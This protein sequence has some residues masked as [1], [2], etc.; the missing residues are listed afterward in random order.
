MIRPADHNDA[1]A[2]A[3]VHVASWRSTYRT[4]L[5]ADFLES[6]SEAAYADRWR[7]FVSDKSTR[8]YVVEEGAGP[9][10]SSPGSGEL[11]PGSPREPRRRGVVGFASGGRERAGETGYEGEMYAIYILDSYQRRGYGREL[12][13]AVVGGLR[14]LGLAEMV[15]W[16][17]REN[18]PAR[19]FYER[20][21][22]VYVRTQPIT[23]GSVTLEEV[24][25]GWPRLDGVRC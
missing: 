19:D 5:P 11:R 22:G 3:R 16:V 6:L 2:I 24:A 20:L 15:V 8:V 9:A 25:Y 21:G 10:D 23:I 7:R 4:L 17:L 12:V 18:H 1:A 13:R 14:E